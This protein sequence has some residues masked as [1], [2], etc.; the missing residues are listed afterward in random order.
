[1]N[2]LIIGFGSMGRRHLEN[3]KSIY[4]DDI[5]IDILHHND[6][7][8]DI[9]R[10]YYDAVFVTNPTFLHYD[11]LLRVQNFSNAFFLE[12]PI[13]MTGEEDISL[14]DCRKLYYTACPL[15]Y[16]RG[17]QY[18]RRNVDLKKVLSVRSISSSYLPDWRRGIDYRNNYS[19]KKELGGGVSIDLIHEWDYIQY[20]FG[21][22][23]KVQSLITKKSSLEIDSDDIA[24]YIGEYA[25]KTVEI[26]L[27]YYGRYTQRKLELICEDDTIE[28]DF[29][30]Q[31]IRYMSSGKEIDISEER[32]DYHKRELL[33][34][35][36]I[37]NGKKENDNDIYTAM[38][39][40]RLA[41]GKV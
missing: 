9:L 11:T 32:D 15:R 23:D 3:F 21:F 12:K 37:V 5:G 7:F 2:I 34:F 35:F 27:D 40:L 41:R 31:K 20:L 22:P 8:D 28:V 30:I 16:T 1:M 38:R 13:F 33:H 18:M 10:D 26:H 17:I 39:T 24:L 36:D 14:L 19:A 6:N 29:V 4:G 25:D